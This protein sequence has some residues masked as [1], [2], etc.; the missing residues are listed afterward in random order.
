MKKISKKSSHHFRIWLFF[1]SVPYPGSLGLAVCSSS[2]S[3]RV[4]SVQ[5]RDW[6]RDGLWSKVMPHPSTWSGHGVI[7]SIEPRSPPGAPIRKLPGALVSVAQKF[8]ETC[9]QA[10]RFGFNKLPFATTSAFFFLK[11][12]TK[13]CF[14]C[15]MKYSAYHPAATSPKAIYLRALLGSPFF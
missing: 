10:K 11:L 14:S 1:F 5:A 9:V 6:P 12:P 7:R 3:P 15:Q 4:S 2:L 13:Q 8:A